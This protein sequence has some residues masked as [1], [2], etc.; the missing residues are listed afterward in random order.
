M[1]H[2]SKAVYYYKIIISLNKI[3][4]ELE[5]MCITYTPDTVTQANVFASSLL[6]LLSNVL[7]ASKDG[8]VSATHILSEI[9]II[10]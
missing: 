10:M 5:I 9:K 8:C 1:R 3:N 4:L 2:V 7:Q 6:L